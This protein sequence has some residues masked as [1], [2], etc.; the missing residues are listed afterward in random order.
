MTYLGVVL[1]LRKVIDRISY[2]IYRH[3][4][5][6]QMPCLG[7]YL[8]RVQDY[9]WLCFDKDGLPMKFMKGKLVFHP[10]Y[11]VYVINDYLKQYEINQS[12]SLE[13]VMSNIA[14][15][16]LKK[17]SEYLG[18]LVYWYQPESGIGSWKHQYYSG[19]TQAHYC[20]MLQRLS[21]VLGD[22]ELVEFAR[23]T[24]DSLLI[25][26]ENGGVLID[27]NG[28]IS[29]EEVPSRPSGLILNGWLSILE[30]VY[31]YF[32]YSQDER[33]YKLYYE[34]AKSLE[35]LLPLYDAEHLKNSYYSLLGNIELR[36]IS[37]STIQINKIKVN[38]LGSEFKLFCGDFD[39]KQFVIHSGWSRDA[40]KKTIEG[41]C[42]EFNIVLSRLSLLRDDHPRIEIEF[43]GKGRPTIELLVKVGDYDPK[44]NCLV[45]CKWQRIGFSAAT[46]DVNSTMSFQIPEELIESIGKPTTF[47]K[48]IGGKLYNVYH[49]IHCDRLRKLGSKTGI[50]TFDEYAKKWEEYTRNWPNMRLYKDVAHESI[51]EG[52][53]E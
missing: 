12:A 39:P 43:K 23:K 49:Y 31:T 11:P 37:N 19:L 15:S 18:A 44:H 21:A 10:M 35:S 17:F 14:R 36:L 6:P 51:S 33:A 34:S 48:R 42:I 27:E 29:I 5:Q 32:S 28:I 41:C 2:K 46:E 45:S 24:F 53:K 20:S 25:P 38:S 47:S 50:S 4:Q 1:R 7:E 9:Y 26:E 40:T 22:S 13:K 8:R 16:S 30:D 52:N 3:F